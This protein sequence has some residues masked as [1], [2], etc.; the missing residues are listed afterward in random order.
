[1]TSR[2]ATSAVRHVVI[3]AGDAARLVDE[4]RLLITEILRRRHRVTCLVQQC[5]PGD[6][7]ALAALHADVAVVPQLSAAR[8]GLIRGLSARRAVALRMMTLAPKAALILDD[9]EPAGLTAG[10]V[11]AGADRIVV[12]LGDLPRSAAG[13]SCDDIDRDALRATRPSLRHVSG[14]LVERSHEAHRL[15]EAGVLPPECTVRVGPIAGVDCS[16]DPAPLPAPGN[17]PVRMLIWV[18]RQSDQAEAEAA[19]AAAAAA[20]DRLEVIVGGPHA[21]ALGLDR[22]QP[23]ILA[24]HIPLD[25]AVATVDA[26]IVTGVRSEL[27]PLV[28]TAL[29]AGRAIIAP[30]VRGVRLAVDDGVNGMLVPPGDRAALAAAIDALSRRPDLAAMGRASRSK[31]ERIFDANPILADLCD[32]L[33]LPTARAGSPALVRA[34]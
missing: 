11:R 4:Q 24:Q 2:Q 22:R 12:A 34:A 17:R 21:R 13:R 3:I 31:A 27:P 7:E 32:A 23:T 30:A 26:V 18:Q 14:V 10:L 6:G 8:H 20:S 33:G 1:M 29:A 5:A 15:R 25:T 16:I 9:V 19:V 28:A